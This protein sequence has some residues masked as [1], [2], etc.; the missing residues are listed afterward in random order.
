MTRVD[1]IFTK[2]THPVVGYKVGIGNGV[3]PTNG[4]NTVVL[5]EC[6][7]YPSK[8]SGWNSISDQVGR[9]NYT[10]DQVFFNHQRVYSIQDVQNLYNLIP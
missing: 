8:V 2:Q 1:I 10:N 6:L 5:T 4:Q 7:I 9:L 3:I